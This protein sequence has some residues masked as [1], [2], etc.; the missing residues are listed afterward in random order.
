M[1]ELE[2]SRKPD[3]GT[4]SPGA[5]PSPEAAPPATIAYD[6]VWSRSERKY[7][8]RAIV[9]LAMN[10]A[11]FCGLCVFI[12]WLHFDRPFDFSLS[13][14]LAPMRF[15]GEQTQNLNDFVLYPVSVEQNPMHGVVLGLLVASIVAVPISVSILYRFPFALPFAGAVLVFAHMPWMALTLVACC[16]LAAV[17]PFRLSFRFGAAL[18]G[19]LPVILY[20]YLATRGTPAQIGTYA[21]PDQ[22]LLLTAPWVLA[23][24]AAVVMLA[25]ILLI[26]RIVNYRPGAVGPVM[27]VMFVAPAIIFTKYVGVD[28]VSYRVLEAEYGPRAQR[29]RLDVTEDCL[30]IVRARLSEPT[31]EPLVGLLFGQPEIQAAVS[32]Q[33]F[34]WLLRDLL[35]DQREVYEECKDFIADYRHSRYVPNVLYIQGWALDLRLGAPRILADGATIQRELYSDFSHVQSEETWLTL[36]EQHPDSP[37]AAAARLRLAQLRMRRGAVDEALA[38]LDEAQRRAAAPAATQSASQ[39]TPRPWLAEDVPERSLG[40]D[41]QPYIREAQHLAELIRANR[42]DPRYG[43]AP[44]V[45]LAAL[46]SRRPGY[47]DQLQ[48]LAHRYRDALLYN[49]L[50]VAWAASQPDPQQRAQQLERCLQAFPDGDARAEAL[51]RLAEIELQARGPD[52]ERIRLAG[53]AHL[54]EIVEHFGASYWGG[55]A[56]ERLRILPLPA[57]TTRPV[58]M[59]AP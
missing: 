45:E 30:E 14:Y 11:L 37:L 40:F 6:T 17:K 25:V 57:E 19:M 50:V 36:A 26:S 21:S 39:P 53:V 43:D 9:L 20:L 16:V 42:P 33:M 29:W 7:R 51:F 38:L 52:Q 5:A 47:G 58:T 13:S 35:T 23:I 34:R 4:P 49:N 18:V 54:R 56:T 59:E 12:H 28:E 46:D 41:P 1:A 15:W 2:D 10:F 3:D 44:L 22:K 24:I 32:R 8:V 27:A 31:G 48:Q 55:E